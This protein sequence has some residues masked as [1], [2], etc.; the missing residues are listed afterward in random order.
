[1]V[2]VM[3]YTLP[4]TYTRHDLL[5]SCFI[6]MKTQIEDDFEL[7]VSP[8]EP[9]IL[10]TSLTIRNTTYCMDFCLAFA[11]FFAGIKLKNEQC[12]YRIKKFYLR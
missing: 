2:E 3:T 7:D 8:K 10:T 4:I 11:I 6:F 9:L 12:A 1:M 5:F